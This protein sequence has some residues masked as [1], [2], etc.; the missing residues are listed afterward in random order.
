MRYLMLLIYGSVA[1]AKY[2]EFSAWRQAV[3]LAVMVLWGAFVLVYTLNRFF[4]VQFQ[5]EP[6]HTAWRDNRISWNV[7]SAIAWLLTALVVW[8][9]AQSGARHDHDQVLGRAVAILSFLLMVW[10]LVETSWVCLRPRHTS[11]MARLMVA[12]ALLAVLLRTY[13]V[14]GGVALAV[15]ETS[16]DAALISGVVFACATHVWEEYNLDVWF[17]LPTIKPP[18]QGADSR[19]LNIPS[20][21]AHK[22]P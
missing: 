7:V 22:H 14:G 21:I 1:V 15:R 16:A 20:L 6:E 4:K 10:S 2:S 12:P 13:A 18:R 19:N 17:A 3:A 8:K 9:H 5:P 11:P